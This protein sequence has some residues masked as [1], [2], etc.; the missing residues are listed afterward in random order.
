MPVSFLTAEQERQYGRYASEPS[1]DQLARHFHLDDADRELV[2]AKRGDHMRLGFAVQLGTVR[3]LGAFLEDPVAVPAGV[4][5]DLARQ[6]AIADPAC[7]DL[8]RQGRMHCHHARQIRARFNYREFNDRS[9]WF[10][11]TRWVYA[12]CWTRTDRPSVLFDRA[13]AWLVAEKILL[14]GASVLERLIASIRARTSHRLCR[15]LSRDITPVQCKRLDDLLLTGEGGKARPLD[16][17]RN[18][19]YLRS[20]AELARAIDRLDEVRLLTIELPSTAHV[21][22]GRIIALARFANVAKAQAVAQMPR[23]RRVATLVA[24]VQTLQATAQDD[25]LDLFDVVVTKLFATP[26]RSASAPGFG[27]CVIWTQPPSSCARPAPSCSTRRSGMQPSGKPPSRSCRG[28][29][30]RKRLHKSTS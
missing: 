7:L 12:L 19:P 25:V 28:W 30:W 21:P 16:C 26:P 11:L 29:P 10:Q 1:P 20:G 15:A 18:G 9:G 8:Y 22:P 14:P 3:F 24:F 13:T 27:L 17:L 23:E 2:T 4:I 5:G 6:L